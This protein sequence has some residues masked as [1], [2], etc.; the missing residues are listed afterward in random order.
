MFF[1]EGDSYA[2]QIR[3]GQMDGNGI[4]C[5]QDKGISIGYWNNNRQV[6]NKKI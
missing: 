4:F 2:G 6:I 1:E 3:K 5:Q